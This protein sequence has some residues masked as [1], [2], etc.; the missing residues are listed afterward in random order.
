MTFEATDHAPSFSNKSRLTGGAASITEPVTSAG[1]VLF[2]FFVSSF[3]CKHKDKGHS[4]SFYTFF[5]PQDSFECDKAF[6]YSSSKVLGLVGF[7]I[8][9]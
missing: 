9:V 3:Q 6:I 5:Y 7:I 2:S 4:L 8:F 1:P